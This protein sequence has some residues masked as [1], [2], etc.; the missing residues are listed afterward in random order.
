MSTGALGAPVYPKRTCGKAAID[1][2][3][4]KLLKRLVP[5]ELIKLQS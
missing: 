3:V 1:V 4:F 2:Q 5:W